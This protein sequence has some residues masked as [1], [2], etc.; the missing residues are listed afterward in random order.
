M[1]KLTCIF[2]FLFGIILTANAFVD[3]TKEEKAKNEILQLMSFNS[4]AP[5]GETVGEGIIRTINSV[6]S[7][8]LNK[9]AEEKGYIFAYEEISNDYV[10]NVRAVRSGQID[11]IVGAYSLTKLYNGIELIYPSVINNPINVAMMPEK[12]DQ[13]SILEDLKGL[14]GVRVEGE[15]LN[16]YVERILSDFKVEKVS[17]LYDAYEKLFVGEVDYVIGGYYYLLSEAIRLGIRPYVSFSKKSLWDIPVFIGIS[18]STKVDKKLLVK[19]LTSWSNT[20]TVKENIMKNLRDY[21]ENL[22]K[23]Y[24]GVVP[25]MFI[26]Q[27]D[28][29][30]A[31][32]NDSAD[33]KNEAEDAKTT[34]QEVSTSQDELLEN[35][36]TET[37]KGEK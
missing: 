3:T 32:E 31:A 23:E 24:A 37:E 33:V 7:S 27:D 13:V 10:N 21:I 30:F 12:I 29:S 15:I 14:K 4:Y 17:N 18:K 6:F 25:P 34:E 16:D 11:M 20:A 1:K 5:F 19:L 26:R 9:F 2:V 22:E 35:I 28:A 36:K 8:E